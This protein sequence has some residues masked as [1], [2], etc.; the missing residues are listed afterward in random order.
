MAEML[1]TEKER[2]FIDERFFLIEVKDG[3]T[4]EII[5]QTVQFFDI[6]STKAKQFGFAMTLKDGRK[7]ACCGDSACAKQ[8]RI[9]Q[10]QYAHAPRRRSASIPNAGCRPTRTTPRSRLNASWR[11]NS[12]MPDLVLYHTEDKS[13]ENRKALYTEEGRQFTMAA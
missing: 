10:R 13:I 4:R 11:R 7:I 8:V 6:H 12:A 3:E 5:G 2:K 9:R 1:L